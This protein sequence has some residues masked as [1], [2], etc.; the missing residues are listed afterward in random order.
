MN[1]ELTI[2]TYEFYPKRGG[3]GTYCHEF[4]LAAATLGYQTRLVGGPSATLP[5]MASES[6]TYRVQPGRNHVSHSI[7]SIWKTRAELLAQFQKV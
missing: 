2:Y 5:E 1:K 3:I 4:A 6:L 7:R